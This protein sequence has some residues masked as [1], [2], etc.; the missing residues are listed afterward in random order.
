[1]I[2]SLYEHLTSEEWPQNLYACA[3]FLMIWFAYS[4]L[5]SNGEK[6]KIER[7]QQVICA[8]HF[9]LMI[10]WV[11]RYRIGLIEPPFEYETTTLGMIWEIGF[12]FLSIA[13]AVLSIILNKGTEWKIFLRRAMLFVAIHT[14]SIFSIPY[15]FMENFYYP[16]SPE[17]SIK[18]EFKNEKNINID[19]SI[20]DPD[21]NQTQ[22][23]DTK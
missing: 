15:F 22:S 2:A 21:Y 7:W 12:V 8:S 10:G 6:G 1:M 4:I 3:S 14:A 18:Y 11:L 9:M 23:P 16:V 5:Q 20:L 17:A 13:F 19:E